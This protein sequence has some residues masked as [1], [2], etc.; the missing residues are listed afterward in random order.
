MTAPRSK[1]RVLILCTG[2]SARSQIA[3]GLLRHLGSGQYEIFSAG[4]R[5]VGV[6]PLAIEV[7]RE[8]GID[9]SAQRSK[10]VAE[11]AGQT[12]ATIITVCDSAAEHCPVFPGAPERLH[13]STPDPVAVSGTRE[14]KMAAFRKVRDALEQRIREFVSAA[15]GARP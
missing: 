11:F 2:N 14:E 4:T 13:W 3:E 15:A 12:F 6:N 9:I 10:S 7:M 8:S 5:P 1:A